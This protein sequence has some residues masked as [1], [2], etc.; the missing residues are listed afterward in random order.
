MGHG[1][2]VKEADV[3]GSN[4]QTLTGGPEDTKLAPSSERL[5]PG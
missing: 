2:N 1:K 4:R 5:I 3:V